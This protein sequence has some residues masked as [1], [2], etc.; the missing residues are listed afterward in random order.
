MQ[1][2]LPTLMAEVAKNMIA[3]MVPEGEK[4]DPAEVEAVTAICM[5]GVYRNGTE[6]PK[7]VLRA[8]SDPLI[9]HL[10]RGLKKARE[11]R[12]LAKVSQF[13]LMEWCFRNGYMEEDW[14]WEWVT[15]DEGRIVFKMRMPLEMIPIPSD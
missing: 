8:V 1:T 4:A 13:F 3:Q 9:E 2:G 6:D 14:R 11:N 7:A 15:K 10:V 12:S 5:M